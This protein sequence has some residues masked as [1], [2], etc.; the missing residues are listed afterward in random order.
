MTKQVAFFV[1]N[2]GYMS[3][4]L[5]II[6]R[7]NIKPMLFSTVKE[8]CI[9]AQNIL[10]IDAIECLRDEHMWQECRSRGIE[11]VISCYQKLTG[12]PS[13][14]NTIQIFHG[15]S[16]KG[17]DLANWKP[18]RWQHIMIQGQHF[19]DPY[20][21]T[22]PK[23][24]ERMQKT[25]FTRACF[26][27]EVPEWDKSKPVL[28]MPS[29]R[30][31]GLLALRENVRLLCNSGLDVMVKLHPINMLNEWFMEG[32]RQ[33]FRHTDRAQLITTDDVRYFRYDEL[34]K[35]SSC[36]VSDFS[37]VVCEYTLLDRPIVIL[38]GGP[39]KGMA[40]RSM[41]DHRHLEQHLFQ[42][43]TTRHMDAAVHEAILDFKPGQYPELFFKDAK[44]IAEA[45]SEVLV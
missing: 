1:N 13:G 40:P 38:R 9:L 43:P 5:G 16:F 33:M 19:W 4:F 10:G 14:L 37:S 27:E 34:M 11:N 17:P 3:H 35:Q 2:H 8:T 21:A 32:V 25:T 23:F 7:L 28:Y 15:V 26:Y 45:I 39:D 29:H 41:R 22:F 24:E 31:S 12:D 30:D 20:R 36:L 44:P 18:D 42:V 6:D